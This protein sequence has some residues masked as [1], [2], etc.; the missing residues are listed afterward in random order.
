MKSIFRKEINSFL[1]SLSGYIV[2]LLFGLA[3]GLFLWILPDTNFMDY[4]YASMELYF[5]LMPWLLLFLTPA[6][7]MR[8]FTE[9]FSRGTIE[10]L[11]T[12]PISNM[13]IIGGKLLAALVLVFIALAPTFIY[14]FSIHYLAL[15]AHSIDIGT[16]L[17]S[18]LSL[19]LL[20]AGYVAIGVFC[21]TLTNNQIVSFLLALFLC[22]IFYSGFEAFSRIPG[23]SGGLDYYLG[24]FGMQYHYNS[25]ITGLVALSGIGY[26]VML[27]LLF[28][29]ATRFSLNM[30][31]YNS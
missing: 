14:A 25:M 8:S 12:K 7:T 16:L 17:A 4:G 13:E 24:L 21:S 20:A 15:D 10:W 5:E 31:Y 30:K 1:G 28:M 2:F 26:F 3:A 23:F 18:I 27:V 22:F 19:V 11:Y 29:M 9:E 6:I